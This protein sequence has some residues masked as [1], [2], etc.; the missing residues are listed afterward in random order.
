MVSFGIFLRNWQIETDIKIV[1][2]VSKNE[3]PC[4]LFQKIHRKRH[5]KASDLE[6]YSL[7]F[8]KYKRRNHFSLVFA[9]VLKFT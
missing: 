8:T 2:C 7:V 6:A 5:D 1:V 4:I 9:V 3:L